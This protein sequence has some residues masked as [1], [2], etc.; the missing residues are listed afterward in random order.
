MHTHGGVEEDCDSGAKSMYLDQEYVEARSIYVDQHRSI[1]VDQLCAPLTALEESA[2]L[3]SE[4]YILHTAWPRICLR[5]HATQ[6]GNSGT[7][8]LDLN[9]TNAS[10]HA[11]THT[12]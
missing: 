12:L 11:Q 9:Y 1:Y 7:A 2:V 8:I 4:A 10:T 3:A 5:T 6:Q